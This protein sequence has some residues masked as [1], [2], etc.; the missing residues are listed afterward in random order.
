MKLTESISIFDNVDA[1]WSNL[2]Q[3]VDTSM[4]QPNRRGRLGLQLIIVGFVCLFYGTNV[5]ISRPTKY[6]K[7][8]FLKQ[9]MNEKINE[10]KKNTLDGSESSMHQQSKEE[11]EEEE[12]EEVRIRD[13]L[14]WKRRHFIMMRLII[15]AFVMLK[16]Q[17]S[18]IQTFKSNINTFLIVFMITDIILEQILTRI[19]M[20][21]SLLVTPILAAFNV[22]EFAMTMSAVDFQSFVISFFIKTA[23]TVAGR[24]YIGPAIEKIELYLQKLTIWLSLKFRF[25]ERIC[26]KTLRRLLLIQTQLQNLSKFHHF[27]RNRHKES[28]EGME[29][30]LGSVVSY[31]NQVQV[32]FITPLVLVFVIF[33]AQETKIEINYS[34]RK[35]DL[36]YYLVFTIII[37]FPQLAINIFLLHILEVLHGCC[38][39]SISPSTSVGRI[40]FLAF[41]K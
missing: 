5:M 36:D 13:A 9:K 19:V 35:S 4:I 14:T 23:L 30:L 6:E 26:R 10:L 16:I 40:Y 34:I 7:L 33:F 32:L 31:S 21:E 1:N 28:G 39:I 2:Q 41:L 15:A 24:V 3:Q 25:F 37:V 12:E 17:F 27:N 22:I 38:S 18:Y 29:A 20:S 8:R 11:S